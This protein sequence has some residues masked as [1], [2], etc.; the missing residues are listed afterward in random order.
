MEMGI[1]IWLIMRIG[2]GMRIM[3]QEWE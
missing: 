3:Q 2:M 1:A